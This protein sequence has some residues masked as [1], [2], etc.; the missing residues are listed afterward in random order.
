MRKVF[1]ITIVLLWSAV[2]C[3]EKKKPIP[4]PVFREGLSTIF[5]PAE[6]EKPGK[7][8]REIPVD[9]YMPKAKKLRGNILVLPGWNFPRNDWYLKTNIRQ[10]AEKHGFLMVFPEMKKSVYET[11]FFPETTRKVF[12][13]PSGLWV[14]K[15]LIPFL[16]KSHKAFLK[17]QANYL[18]GLSTGARGVAIIALKSG[19]LFSA[20]AGFSGDYDQTKMP[21][22]RLMTAIYGPYSKFPDRWKQIDN[23]VS[24]VKLLKVPLYLSHGL[25]DKVVPS[26]QTT[27]F[28][29]SIRKGRPE[30][31]VQ[32]KLDEHAGHN[33]LFW[34]RELKPAFDFFLAH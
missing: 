27:L 8:V 21:R 6:E 16:Q 12:P 26:E 18:L 20:G 17:E 15:I 32:C 7:D 5:V 13:I 33:Y 10:L 11:Q 25:K 24:M 1:W 22:D 34:N 3:S 19:S 23:P 14:Q 28:C 2:S 31:T 4:K 9:V 30:L 29:E